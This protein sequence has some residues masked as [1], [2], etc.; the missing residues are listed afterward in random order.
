LLAAN[1]ELYKNSALLAML[2]KS[3]DDLWVPVREEPETSSPVVATGAWKQVLIRRGDSLRVELH[4]YYL[5][6]VPGYLEVWEKFL[7]VY[8][9]HPDRTA[10]ELA[11]FDENM[12]VKRECV[13]ALLDV[14]EHYVPEGG[15]PDGIES[16]DLCMFIKEYKSVC[17][18][19]VYFTADE[20]TR[21]GRWFLVRPS[22]AG[23]ELTF[24]HIQQ[25][26]THKGPD[27]KLWTM[28]RAEWHCA[29]PPSAPELQDDILRFPTFLQ[30]PSSREG[31]SPL[32][33]CEH[34]MAPVDVTVVG[35]PYPRR[36]RLVALH[37]DHRF[38]C[39]VQQGAPCFSVAKLPAIMMRELGIF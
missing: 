16:V 18:K 6:Q 39:E 24:G 21:K 15:L 22:Q 19:N 14:F 23:E 12:N 36:N 32:A 20:N 28:V 30:S 29:F 7:L 1:P 27:G 38:T 33:A 5:Q 37:R 17:V 13:P 31:W 3:A 35:A 34:F 11:A 2:T 8:I 4:L 9:A 10:A 25:L 26:F